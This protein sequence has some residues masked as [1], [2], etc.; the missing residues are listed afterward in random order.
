[1]T[2]RGRTEVVPLPPLRKAADTGRKIYL[3]VGDGEKA[4]GG[5]TAAAAATGGGDRHGCASRH[6]THRS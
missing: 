6:V 2:E 3:G 4:D 5:G 1:M